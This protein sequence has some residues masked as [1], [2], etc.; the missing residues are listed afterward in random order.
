MK[1]RESRIISCCRLKPNNNLFHFF[2]FIS[3][4]P[5]FIL[6]WFSISQIKINKRRYEREKKV[7]HVGIY[8]ILYLHVSAVLT[9]F[10]YSF[11]CFPFFVSFFL[12]LFILYY[13]LINCYKIVIN[14][15][16]FVIYYLLSFHYYLLF[17]GIVF[18]L[19]E[20][21]IDLMKSFKD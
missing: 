16:L 15:S 1:K 10:L 4:I 5:I 2:D 17:I 13:S 20:L 19:C 6:F 3:R 7:S 9:S 8:F 12:F 21:I 14:F 11:S 18:K